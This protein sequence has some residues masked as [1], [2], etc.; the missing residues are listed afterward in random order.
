MDSPTSRVGNTPTAKQEN[1]AWGAPNAEQAHSVQCLTDS[2]EAREST[3]T[4]ARLSP[5]KSGQNECR[6]TGTD[7]GIRGLACGVSCTATPHAGRPSGRKHISSKS[8]KTG[9]GRDMT[10]PDRTER[11]GTQRNHHHNHHHTTK[12]TSKT[13]WSDVEGVELTCGWCARISRE[14]VTE[15]TLSQKPL[16]GQA[17]RWLNPASSSRLCAC[18]CHAEEETEDRRQ[19]TSESSENQSRVAHMLR[20]RACSRAHLSPTKKRAARRHGSDACTD[21]VSIGL[22]EKHRGVGARRGPKRIATSPLWLYF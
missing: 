15:Q 4:A 22:T 21:S 11:N 18:P 8:S 12:H 13:P 1:T 14:H 10:G 7:R 17:K 5:T 9:Q 16:T 2:S 20:A 19:K 3:R 6:Q